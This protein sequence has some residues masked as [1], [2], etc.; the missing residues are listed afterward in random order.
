MRKILAL[1]IVI[2][3][4]VAGYQAYKDDS[5]RTAL[6]EKVKGVLYSIGGD[7]SPIRVYDPNTMK[8]R[9]DL[10]P[11]ADKF[12]EK[13]YNKEIKF[14]LKN[15]TEFSGSIKNV[16]V[17]EYIKDDLSHKEGD[18]VLIGN[19]I[20]NSFQS[21]KIPKE[22]FIHK[23]VQLQLSKIYIVNG[24]LVE[25]NKKPPLF[26]ELTPLIDD[27][28]IADEVTHYFQYTSPE[29]KFLMS[30]K[31]YRSI[32]GSEEGTKGKLSIEIKNKLNNKDLYIKS[33]FNING[34]NFSEIKRESNVKE[35][36]EWAK[37]NL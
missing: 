20:V 29:T 15:G 11:L 7:T 33:Y 10:Q 22:V 8:Q 31:A 32:S 5:K 23:N 30:D 1:V 17:A 14:I 18:L 34:L 6:E 24:E 37:K 26:L 12:L 3:L 2:A 16:V 36:V 19:F 25:D 35:Y 9:P 28:V 4:A 21:S 27:V 13:H